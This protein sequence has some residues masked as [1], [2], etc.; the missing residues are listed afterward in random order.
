M[1]ASPPGLI[2]SQGG[3]QAHLDL[4]FARRDGQ[5]VLIRNQHRGP[6]QV[7]K[8]GIYRNLPKVTVFCG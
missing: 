6:L 8:R 2:E 4:S 7:Q 5:T 3:W 1:R